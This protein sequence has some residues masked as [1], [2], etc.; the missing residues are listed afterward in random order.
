[1]IKPIHPNRYN[2]N[3]TFSEVAILRIHE[4]KSLFDCTGLIEANLV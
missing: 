3:F 1:M 2:K 4:G